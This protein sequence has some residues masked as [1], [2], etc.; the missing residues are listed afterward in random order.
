MDKR[1]RIKDIAELAGVSKGTVDRVLH[2][3]GNVSPDARSKVAAAMEKLDY[4]PNVIA[5]ALASKKG[6]Q[7]AVLIPDSKN[8]PFWEQP[9]KGILSAKRTLRDYG[10]RID[11]YFFRDADPDH[12]KTLGTQILK[13][14]Y[15]ALLVAPSFL[16]EG[17]A[18]LEKCEEQNLKYIQINT[19]LER[20]HPC[21]L[22]YIGQDSYSSGVLAA[23]LLNYEMKE[24]EKALIF[25]LEKEV[26]NAKHL[27]D[28]QAGF[29]DYFR[30]HSK[31]G[32]QIGQRSF[33]DVLDKEKTEAFIKS[34]FCEHPGISGIFVSTS[35]I[36]RIVPYLKK[37][38]KKQIAL[39]GFD[40]I[41]PNLQ[42]LETEDIHF[43]INQ[44]PYKQGFMGIMNL[45]NHLVLK[46]DIK[47]I[48]L[49]P[50]DMVM[51]ENVQYYVEEEHEKLHIM[52]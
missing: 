4:E 10:V 41:S 1:I 36:F 3:R 28:K 19:F 46:K 27:M 11:F 15:D 24:N 14:P 7:I 12:F 29:E 43:L 21:F 18:L 38:A 50:L 49:L 42:Y 22:S 17:H 52:I 47:R 34:M 16:N 48:Q 23:K 37:Y 9:K 44:N 51:R 30:L 5:S 25:H 32:I 31:K 13:K 35:K 26:Y 40:L 39:I 45:F 33:G 2:N 6:W 20:D 8:D